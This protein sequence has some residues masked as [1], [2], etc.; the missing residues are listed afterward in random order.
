MP[1]VSETNTANSSAKHRWRLLP[2][3]YGLGTL[4]VFVTG[5]CVA[6]SFLRWHSTF[7]L[8]A[9]ILT[10]AGGWSFAAMR[11]KYHRLA[12]ML[13]TPALGVIG[14]FVLIVPMAGVSTR[15]CGACGFI[16]LPSY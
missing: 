16:R 7:G 11:A 10:V 1:N 12:Y 9:A 4:I 13:A 6:L 15:V 14:H 8:M 2:F 5:V 3:Q